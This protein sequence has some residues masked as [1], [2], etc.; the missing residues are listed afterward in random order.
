MT[1]DT[2]RVANLDDRD[3]EIIQFVL[4][5]HSSDTRD[6]IYFLT[7]TPMSEWDEVGNQ[8]NRTSRASWHNDCVRI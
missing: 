7:P 1:V 3:V 2:D 5:S 4:E 8:G 6:R